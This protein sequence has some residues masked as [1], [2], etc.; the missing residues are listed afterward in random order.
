MTCRALQQHTASKSGT[1]LT[2]NPN[3]QLLDCAF[4]L[5]GVKMSWSSLTGCLT[6][7]APGGAM[8]TV[9]PGG[10]SA[11]ATTP[12]DLQMFQDLA[13]PQPGTT[14]LQLADICCQ[15]ECHGLF[16]FQLDYGEVVMHESDECQLVLGPGGQVLTWITGGEEDVVDNMQPER[17]EAVALQQQQQDSEQ[18]QAASGLPVMDGQS[19][20]QAQPLSGQQEDGADIGGQDADGGQHTSAVATAVAVEEPVA[21]AVVMPPKPLA[22]GVKPRLFVVYPTGKTGAVLQATQ[23]GH[24]GLYCLLLHQL[25]SNEAYWLPQSVQLMAQKHQPVFTAVD[26]MLLLD[27]HCCIMSLPTCCRRWL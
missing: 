7:T 26:T 19:S 8:F 12:R 1:H 21:P 13:T 24:T 17:D 3:P 6:V 2:A 9:T 20:S 15:P 10:R 14:P 11:Y 23:C 5:S 22:P 18:Q 16:V 27:L 25:S 4:V